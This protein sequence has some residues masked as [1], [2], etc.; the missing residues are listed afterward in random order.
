MKGSGVHLAVAVAAMVLIAFLDYVTGDQL[1]LFI[2]YPL[3]IAYAAWHC[4]MRSAIVLACAA[5]GSWFLVNHIGSRAY[6]NPFF[7]DWAGGVILLTFLSAAIAANRIRRLLNE[8]TRLNRD[9]AAAMAKIKKLTGRL[10][11][12]VGCKKIQDEAGKWV[13]LEAYII[14]HSEEDFVFQQRVCPACKQ[15]A[16]TVTS[17]RSES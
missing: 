14:E 5:A 6:S 8:Q 10:P 1:E 4:G 11:I 3:P 16:D 12:C 2:L 13:Q 7:A 17:L 9:L 15:S